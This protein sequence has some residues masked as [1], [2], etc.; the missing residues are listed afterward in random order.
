MGQVLHRCATTTY[1]V[2]AAIQ[3]SKASNAEFAE[4]YGVNQKTIR[5]W[6]SR[7]SVEDAPMGPKRFARPSCHPRKK[8]RASPF[9]NT[10]FCRW[11]TV[12]K[13]YKRRSRI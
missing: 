7:K 4:Q 8:R 10:R 12:F 11:T 13:C 1:A 5:K 3:R 6:R 9:A 2:R